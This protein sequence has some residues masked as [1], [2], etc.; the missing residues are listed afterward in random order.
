VHFKNILNH[1]GDP[2]K[3]EFNQSSLAKCTHESFKE[4]SRAI[5]MNFH[6]SSGAR[7]ERKNFFFLLLHNHFLPLHAQ[8]ATANKHIKR[9]REK[10]KFSMEKKR[11]IISYQFG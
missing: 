2:F 3:H 5:L 9:A 11:A 6:S 8:R 4:I 10:E 1:D 7:A